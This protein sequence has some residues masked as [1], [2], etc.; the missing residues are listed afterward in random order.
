MGKRRV[1]FMVLRGV[2][3]RAVSGRR[4]VV[5]PG[6]HNDSDHSVDAVRCKYSVQMSRQ[7]PPSRSDAQRSPPQPAAAAA[8]SPSP[9][10]DNVIRDPLPAASALLRPHLRL[11]P[12][13]RL[14]RRALRHDAGVVHAPG[15]P[16]AARVPR[17]AGRHPHA[18]RLPRPG[19]GERD[20][21]AA[22][23]PAQGRRGHLLQRHRRAAE[24]RGRRRRDPAGP[25][26]RSS[27]RR[28]RMPRAWPSSR[29]STPPAR[30][31]IRPHH[32][33]RRSARSPS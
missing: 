17:A 13:A 14:P 15:G 1:R 18:R 25:R 32:R 33:G 31:G 12:R 19:D 4:R 26:A 6:A 10:R 22:G 23:A 9:I 30:R 2:R 7:P 16:L 27:A 20:H 3:R 29:R 28:T 8:P 11:A 24:A 5:V 21:A